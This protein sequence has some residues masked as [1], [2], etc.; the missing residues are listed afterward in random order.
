M[1]HFI[2]RLE[3]QTR[4]IGRTIFPKCQSHTLGPE[5]V[6]SVRQRTASSQKAA[7]VQMVVVQETDDINSRKNRGA[8]LNILI[9]QS[10][11]LHEMLFDS[12]MAF[13]LVT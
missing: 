10:Y 2:N 4:K 9:P 8:T 13:V 11:L 1:F 6:G 12:F 5:N 7:G 3:T